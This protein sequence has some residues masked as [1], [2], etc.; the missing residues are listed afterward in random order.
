M[1][2]NTKTKNLLIACGAVAA[3]IGF[4]Y[5]LKKKGKA[6]AQTVKKAVTGKYFTISELSKTNQKLD[7]TPT[8]AAKE[9]LQLLIDNVL[10]PLRE[11]YGKPILVSSGYRSAAVN[12][13]VGGAA[14]SQHTKGQ[15]ADLTTRQGK[16]GNK[17]LFEIIRSQGGF[18]QLINEKDYSWVHVSFNPNGNRG[19]VLRYDGKKYYKMT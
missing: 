5:L 14:N 3:F 9:N 1:K 15:A 2:L 7:N 11:A 12:K 16:E 8:D 6:M 17:R 19:E 13:A 10:D 4:A 18:D